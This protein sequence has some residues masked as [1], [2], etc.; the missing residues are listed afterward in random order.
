MMY[1]DE[2]KVLS[3]LPRAIMLTLHFAAFFDR[4]V[5]FSWTMLLA[6]T[7]RRI[8]CTDMILSHP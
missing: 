5:M 6:T 1:R 2:E 7:R 8:Y 4:T 3:L